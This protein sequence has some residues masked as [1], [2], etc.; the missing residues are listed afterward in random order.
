MKHFWHGIAIVNTVLF[1]LL[2]IGLY[3][4]S[5]SINTESSVS[6][7]VDIAHPVD[8]NIQDMPMIEGNVDAN[9]KNIR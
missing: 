2:V 7:E 5:L 8:I 6:G 3:T 4:G 1:A 9:I